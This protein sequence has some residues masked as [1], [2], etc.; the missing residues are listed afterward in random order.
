M[1]YDMARYSMVWFSATLWYNMLWYEITVQLW[2][3]FF[4]NLLEILRSHL[5]L[6]FFCPL[7]ITN[8]ITISSFIH[9]SKKDL[10]Y[11]LLFQIVRY[12]IWEAKMRTTLL[13]SRSSAPTDQKLAPSPCSSGVPRSPG[14]S[15]TSGSRRKEEKTWEV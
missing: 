7:H 6:F 3:R 1:W 9:I 14:R 2:C 4:P 10:Q 15:L 8:S 11:C 5:Y 12:T 13:R